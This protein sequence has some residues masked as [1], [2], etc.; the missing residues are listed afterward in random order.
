VDRREITYIPHCSPLLPRHHRQT[1]RSSDPLHTPA[2]CPLHASHGLPW[3]IG[4]FERRA[5]LGGCAGHLVV[6]VR[7]RPLEA[8]CW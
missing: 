7:K 2:P 4:V 3:P 1:Y 8:Y 5:A 6:L